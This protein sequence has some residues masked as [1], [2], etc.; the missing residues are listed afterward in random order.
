MDRIGWR[1]APLATVLVMSM[2]MPLGAA[3]QLKSMSDAV[4]ELETW[5][6]HEAKFPRRDEAPKIQFVES[7]SA[8][9]INEASVTIGRKT[10]GLYDPKT[11]T[12]TLVQPWNA[13]SLQDRSVL[14]HE[15][16]HHRQAARLWGCLGAMEYPAYKLQEAWLNENGLALDVNW[17]AIVLAANCAPRDLHPD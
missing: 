1:K 15:L 17:I 3:A 14:L 4:E 8:A 10:R 5:L 13:D 7:L 12:N 9:G 6:D 16:I 2:L 11:A